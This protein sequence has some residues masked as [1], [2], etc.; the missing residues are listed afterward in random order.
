MS[1]NKY[2]TGYTGVSRIFENIANVG[3]VSN[4]N[5]DIDYYTLGNGVVYG[6]MSGATSNIRVRIANIPYG[7]T[8][9]SSSFASVSITAILIIPAN[10][11]PYIA[12][13]YSVSTGAINT[14]MSVPYFSGGNSSVT[15][16]STSSTSA[17]YLVQQFN[18]VFTGT[19][20]PVVFT[21]V[22]WMQP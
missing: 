8:I 5:I 19:S 17:Q 14:T 7:T 18:L 12:N 1:G 4:G 2:F 16:A 20:T 21:N 13:Q 9:A 6:N 15:L 22:I 10:Q 11:A 3:T